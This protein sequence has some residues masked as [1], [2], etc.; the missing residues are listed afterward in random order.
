MTS[1][2]VSNGART[3]RITRTTLV[4]RHA[5]RGLRDPFAISSSPWTTDQGGVGDSPTLL[6][7][8][9]SFVNGVLTFTNNEIAGAA[10]ANA[11]KRVGVGTF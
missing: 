11:W 9:S 10:I 8:V 1:S 6:K 2:F 7:V 4:A 3:Y 5:A